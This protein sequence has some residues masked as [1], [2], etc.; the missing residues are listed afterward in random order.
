MAKSGRLRYTLPGGVCMLE[1]RSVVVVD[2]RV[3]FWSLVRLLLKVAI[4]AIP[5]ALLLAVLGFLLAVVGATFIGNLGE[6]LARP[7]AIEA[8]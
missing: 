5:A 8:R 3:P 2:V 4:A 7:A 6:R 1:D